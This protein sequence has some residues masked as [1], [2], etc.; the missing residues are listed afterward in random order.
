MDQQP[1][2]RRG[3]EAAGRKEYCSSSQVLEHKPEESS[4]IE[5]TSVDIAAARHAKPCM[6]RSNSMSSISDASEADHLASSRNSST[7]NLCGMSPN[8]SMLSVSTLGDLP[9]QQSLGALIDRRCPFLINK[10]ASTNNIRKLKPLESRNRA[11]AGANKQS[12]EKQASQEVEELE[13]RRKLRIWL[14][15]SGLL[16]PTAVAEAQKEDL[17]ASAEEDERNEQIRS[18][19]ADTPKMSYAHSKSWTC[20]LP[21]QTTCEFS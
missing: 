13:R 20:A 1:Q 15:K 4:S 10:A 11:P 7:S 2:R 3:M 14:M 9:E 8:S 19:K 21:Q 6:L 18:G 16:Q 5:E 12:T 17:S